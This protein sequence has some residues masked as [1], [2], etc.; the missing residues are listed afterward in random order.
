MLTCVGEINSSTLCIQR[1]GI[2]GSI[3]LILFVGTDDNERVFAVMAEPSRCRAK[4]SS[5][6][7][8]ASVASDYYS[9]RIDTVSNFADAN[10]SITSDDVGFILQAGQHEFPV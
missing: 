4:Y 10:T 3:G 5:G 8:T 1:N 2:S 9:V 7:C 6:D